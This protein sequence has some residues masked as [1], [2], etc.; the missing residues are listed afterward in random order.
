[1]EASTDITKMA[2]LLGPPPA[3][4]VTQRFSEWNAERD[5][6]KSQFES[7]EERENSLFN[8]AKKAL[9]ASIDQEKQA[10]VGSHAV[11]P[12]VLQF[13]E[14]K[15]VSQVKK[16]QHV[17]E[18]KKAERKQSLEQRLLEHI[19]ACSAFLGLAGAAT[20]ETV[21]SSLSLTSSAITSLG[22][23]TIGQS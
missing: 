13:F 17:Y 21:S 2:P 15:R 18:T 16:L 10:V 11:H 23:L 9:E 4:G 19:E 14:D 22:P 1:M 5:A 20:R 7:D 6:I 3:S 8:E 12:S